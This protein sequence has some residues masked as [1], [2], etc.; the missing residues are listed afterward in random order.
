MVLKN[1]GIEWAALKWVP[2]KGDERH[3]ITFEKY[4]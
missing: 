3:Y 4:I 2:T 1:K